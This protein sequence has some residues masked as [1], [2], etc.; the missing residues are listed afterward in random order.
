MKN[1]VVVYAGGFQP[2]HK[3]HLSSYVQAKKAFPNADFYVAASA[4]TKKRPI[5]YPE[6]KFLA[7]QAGVKP[8]DFPNIVVKSPMKPDEVL[9]SYDPNEDVFVL[10]RSE[11]DPVSYTKKDGSPGY[12]QPWPGIDDAKPFGQH[13]Y[14]YV[15]KKHDF[16]LNGEEVFS[17]TQV[18]DL[19]S[20]SND[21]ERR[22]IIDQLYP[23]SKNKTMIKQVLDQYIGDNMNTQESIK[24]LISQIKP[25]IKEASVEQKAKF[26]RLL[27]SAKHRLMKEA[28][29]IYVGDF[30][31]VQATDDVDD[32]V[33][34]RGGKKTGRHFKHDDIP[35]SLAS[36]TR[37][38]A[39]AFETKKSKKIDYLSEV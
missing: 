36:Q 29:A 28:K 26:V 6:K 5:P 22:N 14:V 27:E 7:T 13:G 37:Q 25:L 31:Y 11:R 18:R 4:D 38:P 24:R 17:G 20:N 15:T 1:I 35:N 16:N 33:E 39:M 30:V 8:E 34:Y 12:Y 2:F 23:N 32:W 19:Y 10:V 9:K 21:K 3:G